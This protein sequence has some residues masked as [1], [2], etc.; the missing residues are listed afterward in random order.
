MSAAAD[1]ARYPWVK[2]FRLVDVVGSAPPIPETTEETDKE[3]IRNYYRQLGRAKFA[4][5]E[6][7]RRI[8]VEVGYPRTIAGFQNAIHNWDLSESSC[9]AAK[10]EDEL[11]VSELDD[12]EVN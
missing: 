4:A 11:H 9:P 1:L 2:E 8:N 3:E 5:V 7:G 12:D 6:G 10:T